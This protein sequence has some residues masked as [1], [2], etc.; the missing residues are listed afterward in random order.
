M[1]RTF[2][3]LISLL[4]F[5]TGAGLPTRGVTNFITLSS[6]TAHTALTSINSHS[7]VAAVIASDQFP[8]DD[9]EQTDLAGVGEQPDQ[10]VFCD[11]ELDEECLDQQLEIDCEEFP[12]A[13]ACLAESEDQLADNP[14]EI[15]LTELDDE[16]PNVNAG[17]VTRTA[18]G[19]GYRFLVNDTALDHAD[20]NKGDG[21]CETSFQVS[22]GSPAQLVYTCTLRAALEEVNQLYANGDPGP[23]EIGIATTGGPAN[24][25]WLNT[26]AYGG[27]GGISVNPA[28]AA[29]KRNVTLDPDAPVPGNTADNRIQR[30]NA[31]TVRF[32]WSN[33]GGSCGSPSASSH[34]SFLMSCANPEDTMLGR[35]GVNVPGNGYPHPAGDY[36]GWS[37]DDL[38]FT[39]IG[40]LYN[41]TAPVLIDLDYRLSI[42]LINDTSVGNNNQSPV[43]F[44]LN[45]PNITLK[46]LYDTFGEETSIY[47]GP[48]A[49]DVI[50]TDGQSTDRTRDG[51]AE[52]F[53]VV[54]GGAKNTTLKNFKLKG[55]DGIAQWNGWWVTL[56]S[57]SPA[58]PVDG[59]TVDN[60][61]YWANASG[62]CGYDNNIGCGGSGVKLIG[63]G[64]SGSPVGAYVS[65][66]RFIN[67]FMDNVQMA[68]SSTNSYLLDARK[69]NFI[70]GECGTWD[71]NEVCV[72]GAPTILIDNNTVTTGSN[73]P[74]GGGY[75]VRAAGNVTSRSLIALAGGTIAGAVTITNNTFRS[76]YGT[77]ASDGLIHI[78][79]SVTG[80]VTI[81]S[82]KIPNSDT[83]YCA[84]TT[85]SQTPTFVTDTKVPVTGSNALFVN[86]TGAIS[87]P[88]LIDNNKV[89]TTG[90]FTNVTGALTG[91]LII[92][93]NNIA[94]ASVPASNQGSVLNFNTTQKSAWKIEGN[95]FT[96]TASPNRT[97]GSMFWVNGVQD[98]GSNTQLSIA[99]N[100]ITGQGTLVF[101][102]G[103]KKGNVSIASNYLTWPTDSYV[104][105]RINFDGAI[106]SGNLNI[107]NN[108]IQNP[109]GM[110][111]GG[112]SIIRLP[113]ANGITGTAVIDSNSFNNLNGCAYGGNNT[114]TS[115]GNNLGHVLFFNSG[116]KV[117]GDTGKLYVKNNYFQYLNPTA[118]Q[119]TS[120]IAWTGDRAENISGAYNNSGLYIQNN[121]FDWQA[122]Q[123]TTQPI[124]HLQ[125]TGFA[126]VAQNLFSP[127][128]PNKVSNATNVPASSVAEESYLNYGQNATD[129]STSPSD[130][131]AASLYGHLHRYDGIINTWYPSNVDSAG[132]QTEIPQAI[133]ALS[134][135][136]ANGKPIAYPLKANGT[137]GNKADI[138]MG[139]C[140][141]P[142]R[143]SPPSDI[144][145]TADNI[146]SGSRWPSTTDQPL[147]Y[148]AAAINGSATP[149]RTTYVA[150]TLT[151]VVAAGTTLPAPCNDG[152]TFFKTNA[153]GSAAGKYLCAN[154]RYGNTP[155]PS[156]NPTG[157]S[158]N[159]VT[160]IVQAADNTFY[161]AN[162]SGAWQTGTTSIGASTSTTVFVQDTQQVYYRSAITGFGWTLRQSVGDA[163]MVGSETRRW[164]GQNWVTV[165]DGSGITNDI[166]TLGNLTAYHWASNAWNTT[167][168]PPV[169]NGFSLK[170][171]DA[172]GVATVYQR[173]NGAW[174][175]TATSKNIFVDVYWTKGNTAGNSAAELYLGRYPVV[176]G[177]NADGGTAPSGKDDNILAV[178]L[179][180]PGDPR[181]T[182]KFGAG[183]LRDGIP[184]F[185]TVSIGD[186]R[187]GTYA[188]D[189]TEIKVNT[190]LPYQPAVIVD[191]DKTVTNQNE[192]VDPTTGQ[193]NGY[194]RV[195]TI[196]T[197]VNPNIPAA[198]HYSRLAQIGGDC[199]PKL[200]V[201][202]ADGTPKNLSF[203][204]GTAAAANQPGVPQPLDSNSTVVQSDPT[205]LRDIHFT[206]SSDM[207]LNLASVVKAVFGLNAYQT[208]NPDRGD[209][210]I[211][212]PE[213]QSWAAPLYSIVPDDKAAGTTGVCAAYP[214]AVALAGTTPPVQTPVIEATT[215][216]ANPT[217]LTY[218][219]QDWITRTASNQ[220]SYIAK[221]LTPMPAGTYANR[222]AAVNNTLFP[223][224]GN[225]YYYYQ[226][227][228]NPNPANPQGKYEVVNDG[229]TVTYTF[230][231]PSL[232]TATQHELYLTYP[233]NSATPSTAI[234]FY[235]YTG[236]AWGTGVG[237][238]STELNL[239]GAPANTGGC[240]NNGNTV[241]VVDSDSY[242]Y[243]NANTTTA[244]SWVAYVPVTGDAF[245]SNGKYY[246]YDGEHWREQNGT[247]YMFATGSASALV[248]PANAAVVRMDGT[249]V[250]ATAS[251]NTVFVASTGELYDRTATNGTA[252]NNVWT[253]RT[254]AT[255]P[256]VTTGAPVYALKTTPN[257]TPASFT[258]D[259]SMLYQW[260]NNAGKY[261]GKTPAVNEKFIYPAATPA[262]AV[263]LINWPGNAAPTAVNST[264]NP[265]SGKLL[266]TD[267]GQVYT[268]T[269]T[270]GNV[271]AWLPGQPNGTTS[272]ESVMY[273]PEVLR[274][275]ATT[276]IWDKAATTGD[277]LFISGQRYKWNNSTSKWTLT[278]GA[279]GETLYVGELT[280]SPESSDTYIWDAATTKWVKSTTPFQPSTDCK[281]GAQ[282]VSVEPIAIGVYP[283]SGYYLPGNEPYAV[284][285]LVNNGENPTVVYRTVPSKAGSA[286]TL[287]HLVAATTDER[288]A[289]FEPSEWDAAPEGYSV[290]ELATGLVY[291]YNI[292]WEADSDGNPTATIESASWLGTA[293]GGQVLV[294]SEQLVYEAPGAQCV[295][296][297]WCAQ[298]PALINHIFLASSGTE[299]QYDGAT[300][301]PVTGNDGDL[302]YLKATGQTLMWVDG[303]WAETQP[304]DGDSVFVAASG[305][306]EAAGTVY[307]YR[308][309]AWAKANGT[310]DEI[311]VVTSDTTIYQWAPQPDPP[312][313]GMWKGVGGRYPYQT[314]KLYSTGEM[315][316]WTCPAGTET[317]PAPCPGGFW[318]GES[319]L[320][321]HDV[322]EPIYSETDF[323]IVVR[324]ND[325]GVVALSVPALQIQ[326][327]AGL[328]NQQAAN[329]GHP[330]TDNR[331]TFINPLA[332]STPGF[333]LVAGRDEGQTY[334][335]HLRGF[336]GAEVPVGLP[337]GAPD[338]PLESTPII[339][340]P[341]VPVAT[342][343]IAVTKADTMEATGAGKCGE[344]M[345]VL[346]LSNLMLGIPSQGIVTD[347]EQVTVAALTNPGA[348]ANCKVPLSHAVNSLDT[349]YDK[350]V[351]PPVKVAIFTTDPRLDMVISAYGLA[352]A[353]QTVGAGPAAALVPLVHAPH[354]S[355]VTAAAAL[356]APNLAAQFASP[357]L[358]SPHLRVVAPD[359][360]VTL[361]E[362]ICFIG[363]VEN[364]S[365]DDWESSLREVRISSDDPRQDAIGTRGGSEIPGAG[366]ALST[367]PT[368]GIGQVASSAAAPG[369]IRV[370]D[371]D[372]YL[373][374]THIYVR[375][376]SGG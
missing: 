177:V 31:Y 288:V 348:Y 214:A 97:D 225:T 217:A 313:G 362:Q 77:S 14:P 176:G 294:A 91:N 160:E 53:L 71:E 300:W 157:T 341:P 190:K 363:T 165:N 360:R 151:R 311:L 41:V 191:L 276:G 65:G 57:T 144:S 24:D 374:C 291:T 101:L 320:V 107:F 244:A 293:A 284:P 23:F 252:G 203:D 321:W 76:N 3:A 33:S 359:S 222:P 131:A 339:A 275:N 227:N 161:T 104:A 30:T 318:T 62:V 281:L 147:T 308:D 226:T 323:D 5:C 248:T 239:N 335:V 135:I 113:N 66:L 371:V 236:S 230:V 202:Q 285:Q 273:G 194:L 42:N 28:V 171:V 267:T 261:V 213:N 60:V 199:S 128:T 141:A 88:V 48:A 63:S 46:G 43:I 228:A 342:V 216:T 19:G 115:G 195:Q 334:D 307:E 215:I 122:S 257:P 265:P 240:G 170:S 95:T 152:E 44:F 283:A 337:Y 119:G 241:Y 245:R 142:L 229:T 149:T 250:A 301:V 45:G 125:R 116:N 114:C 211:S 251:G 290:L 153:T 169:A 117:I 106:F 72:P 279:A 59:F 164:D 350:L 8:T 322:G 89:N 197:N 132:A 35:N 184:M 189:G 181:L 330:A 253:K 17:N 121:Y 9:G 364:T 82:N 54:R 354:N 365:T 102:K 187:L 185:E 280:G 296:P 80:P 258:G 167:L 136:N 326:S 10:P 329:A 94:S 207:P 84:Q 22:Q 247:D 150:A 205:M 344:T 32:N 159:S 172:T 297:D 310:L 312:G 174:V 309:G 336:D 295:G 2:A 93:G 26:T 206:L 146:L 278:P 315:F 40:I 6:S 282:I 254:A 221:N 175:P 238:C 158:G 263:T 112:Y 259:S 260:D 38:G 357:L 11:R 286:V 118:T 234:T 81:S 156:I 370:P 368:L 204:P 178:V 314:L 168:A 303:D 108:V 340:A 70:A 87:G 129:T 353:G 256:N 12:E 210:K 356:A 4:L 182:R 96:N 99:E 130:K 345:P 134:A 231:A 201:K 338:Q 193:V 302:I 237:Y 69:A 37:G 1:T 78:S 52:R 317:D 272:G 25:G 224:D 277:A 299:Y 316:F 266:A 270:P 196:D 126:Y 47:V 346:N 105:G 347:P 262:N 34:Y 306:I 15:E 219:A 109:N 200:T 64:A 324:L 327:Q 61:R 274:W 124:I 268:A 331:I 163:V 16:L 173:I 212:D 138:S 67:N 271:M 103:E 242:Y 133:A 85:W 29:L 143:V 332:V 120:A 13:A 352:G 145:N 349:Q 180:Q 269:N 361:N 232:A 319:D 166:F 111:P 333:P 50:I 18:Q 223:N 186:S 218:Y 209:L 328:A 343:T 351:L 21:L 305:T 198:S 162:T 355:A 358:G 233:Y 74:N 51:Y 255:T 183:A 100:K 39:D 373:W 75:D 369:T 90:Q 375:Q 137:P 376:P 243:R 192:P 208:Q 188:A 79:S 154:G 36:Y 68:N 366:S 292:I 27:A 372:T 304:Q 298:D 264:G 20:R 249:A 179:P 56:K 86:L 83:T 235:R 139:A 148:T 110:A 289:T 55:Y 127:Q 325:S 58:N 220:I 367:G 140:I 49:S 73:A 7:A 287:E 92:T 98:T 123:A 155:M 246:R